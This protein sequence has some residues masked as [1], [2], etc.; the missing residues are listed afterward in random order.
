MRSAGTLLSRVRAPSPAPWLDRGPERL[1][2]PCCELA[3]YKNK[4]LIIRAT[5]VSPGLAPS[6]HRLNAAHG[7][8]KKNYLA[9]TSILLYLMRDNDEA[10][11]FFLFLCKASPQQGDL[12]L[13]GH[14]SCQGTG[15]K[16]GPH[17]RRVPAG[18]RVGSLSSEPPRRIRDLKF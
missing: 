9:M 10:R 6:G 4:Q 13:L 11:R 18:L 1:K 3:L 5:A 2:S 8:E 12:R 7:N 16:A 17:D 15:G 14:S